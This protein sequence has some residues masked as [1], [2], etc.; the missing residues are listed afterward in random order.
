MGLV[1]LGDRKQVEPMVEC[2]SSAPIMLSDHTHTTL[3]G[4]CHWFTEGL[5]AHGHIAIPATCTPLEVKGH[6]PWTQI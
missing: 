5:H 6:T 3:Y 1:G 2:L 4:N